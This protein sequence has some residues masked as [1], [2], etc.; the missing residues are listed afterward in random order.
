MSRPRAL[1]DDKAFTSV[2]DAVAGAVLGV[3]RAVLE[4][5]GRST[6]GMR[7]WIRVRGGWT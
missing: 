3:V 1:G 4:G 7:E 5:S 2:Y 6:R